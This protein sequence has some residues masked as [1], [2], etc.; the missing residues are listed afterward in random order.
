MKRIALAISLIVC[1]AT[2]SMAQKWNG[3]TL[4]STNNS[5]AT[6]L[7]DTTGTVVKT[8]THP[9]SYKTG[10]STYME[11]GGTLVRTVARSGNSFSGGPICGE[12]Q[13]VDYNGNVVW[14][15]V[16]STANYCT[17]HD[18]CPMPNGN[19]LLIAYE[20]KTAAQATQ[21]GCSQNIEIWSEKIVEVQPTG[22]TT[23]T[24]VWEWHL[25]DHLV[26]NYD[27]SKDNYATTISDHPELININYNTQKDW[28]HMNG[29]DYN[30]ILDQITFSSHNLNEIY[31]ID[32]STTTAEAASHS[33][34][35]SGKGGDILYRWGN[36]AAYGITGIP[37]TLNVV[38]DA[39]WIPEGS[40]NAGRL[41]C[42]NNGGTPSKST[43]DFIDAPV[44]G[45]VY[46]YTAGQAFMPTTYSDRIIGVGK[47]NNQ[48]GSQQLPNGNHLI[49]IGMSGVMSETNSNGT[50]LWTKTASGAVSKA[51]RYSDCYINNPAPAIPTITENSGVLSSTSA[52]TYQWYLNGQAISGATSQNYTP[53]VNGIYL[54]RVTDDNGCVYSYSVGYKYTGA[55]TNIFE[56]SAGVGVKIYPNPTT[57]FV[58]LQ[59]AFTQNEFQVEIINTL[60]Q[61]V[62]S[63][64]N[65]TQLDLNNLSNGIYSI[66]IITTDN[67]VKTNKL[68][69][70]R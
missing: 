15:F 42:F 38:H 51:Y 33:G 20:R 8:W 61:Q 27:P 16:Y 30:P 53:T 66:H 69:I 12:V 5:T 13:K 49:T 10:Y 11:P 39:H 52:T 67:G 6:Y 48:G 50:N 22:A 65:Q 44:N 54:V 57:G 62:Y 70:N 7:Y 1:V 41:A 21:A 17:H 37:K 58:T 36:P 18:I 28:I 26:Q 68:I 47:T 24:V 40:P 34:G 3:K 32:H 23:G 25:W 14:D 46:D 43:V 60:G 35:N 2:I 4:Y 29:I 19:V 55:I 64:K 63:V 9:S 59:V 45:Y 31:V 56:L